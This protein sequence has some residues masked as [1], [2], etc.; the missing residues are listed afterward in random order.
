MYRREVIDET[1][2]KELEHQVAYVR[3]DK[4]RLK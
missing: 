4:G 3:F 1:I 2:V